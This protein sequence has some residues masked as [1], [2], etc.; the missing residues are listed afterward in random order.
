M[1]RYVYICDFDDVKDL[2]ETIYDTPRVSIVGYEGGHLVKAQGLL[3]DFLDE[4]HFTKE[5][6]RRNGVLKNAKGVKIGSYQLVT[7]NLGE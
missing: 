7:Q 5:G 3:N 4:T 6:N 2:K 1:K